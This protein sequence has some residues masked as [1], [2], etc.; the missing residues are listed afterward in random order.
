MKR[1]KFENN[2]SAENVAYFSNVNLQIEK[3]AGLLLSQWKKSKGHN[4]NMLKEKV[5]RAAV[6]V[7]HDGKNFFATLI[8]VEA[9]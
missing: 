4:A 5:N 1:F 6:G 7:V 3:I 9:V 2:E 8:L